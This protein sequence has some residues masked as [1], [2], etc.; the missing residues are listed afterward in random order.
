MD[1]MIL[2]LFSISSEMAVV[3]GQ[4]LSDFD[5]PL[6]SFLRPVGQTLASPEKGWHSPVLHPITSSSSL[7]VVSSYS[8]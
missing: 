2:L 5:K 7:S 1:L 6:S 3:R 8:L 4:T